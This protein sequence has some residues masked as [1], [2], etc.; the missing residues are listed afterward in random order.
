MRLEMNEYLPKIRFISRYGKY[1]SMN[2]SLM[3]LL[4]SFHKHREMKEME[5]FQT[6]AQGANLCYT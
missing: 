3:T 5:T 1:T 2:Q 6:I 4:N